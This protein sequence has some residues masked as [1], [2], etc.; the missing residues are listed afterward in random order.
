MLVGSVSS[1]CTGGYAMRSLL[2]I[3]LTIG[4]VALLTVPALAQRQRQPGGGF[5]QRGGGGFGTLLTNESVQK[6]L[7]IEKD[8]A[9]KLKEAVTKVTD[10]HKDETAKIRELPQ[11][12]RPAKQQELN[13]TI[14]EETLKA[15][16]DI[17]KPE[18][19]TRLKQIELQQAN[20]RAF[21]RP[22]VQ[23]ALSLEDVQ[24]EKIKTINDDSQKAMRDLRP[25]GGG[26]KPAK[27]DPAVTEKIATL[28]KETAEK[29]QGVLTDD[30]KKTWKTMI[31]D[32]FTLVRPG[33]GNNNNQ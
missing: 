4:V 19:V 17:L 22:D 1:F 33:R 30:Q 9:D 10:A 32:S 18:Q 2:R 7:K 25:A 21:S 8:T 13:K 24:I 16:S 11:A 6:E 29:I 20:T 3:T 5:G 26:G 15:V 14:N 12:E 27:P 28:R 31:G 23:K